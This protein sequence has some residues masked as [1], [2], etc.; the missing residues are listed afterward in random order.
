MCICLAKIQMGMKS[1]VAS[2]QQ[3]MERLLQLAEELG[4]QGHTL[5][6]LLAPP[7]TAPQPQPAPVQPPSSS[8][9]LIVSSCIGAVVHIFRQQLSIKILQSDIYNDSL[10]IIYLQLI[11][12]VFDNAALVAALKEATQK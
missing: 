6:D 9:Y 1:P 2:A 10:L 5:E 3:N 7:I 4:S 8:S 12:P 11:P